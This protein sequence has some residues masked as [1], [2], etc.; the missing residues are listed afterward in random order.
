MKVNR[1]DLCYD[2]RRAHLDGHSEFEL[3]DPHPDIR[4]LFVQFDKEY[5]W[6]SLGAVEVLWSSKMTLYVAPA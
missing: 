4:A 2:P 6:S 3:L 5:F 1:E